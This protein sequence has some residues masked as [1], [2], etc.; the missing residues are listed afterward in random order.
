MKLFEGQAAV[1]TGAGEGIGYAIARQLAL[2]G[3][4]VLLNDID[5]ALAEKAASEISAEG[6][7]CQAFGGDASDIETIRRMVQTAVTS[8]GR[9]DMAVANAGLTFYGDFF[10]FKPENFERLVNLNLRGSYFLAQAAARQMRLQGDGG[11][12]I[13]MS[14]VT[15]HQAVP[16]LAAYG[17]TK[18][19]L[20]MLAKTLVLELSP[21]QITINAVAPGATLT[22]RNVADDPDFVAN[23]A[24]RIPTQQIV[25]PD[26]IAHAA[27][28]L[29]SKQAGQITGQTVVVDG[30]W[31]AI[32]PTP[33]MDFVKE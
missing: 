10:E 15:G 8:Y 4:S 31:T 22:P 25:M 23:W 29:L 18:A 6:G 20:E 30:G 21:H 1:I 28:F 14:S 17:M 3:A 5:V 2:Q 7:I 9:L 26:D 11:R 24:S 19:A 32:S 33:S 27:L 12:I 16:Y 13:L